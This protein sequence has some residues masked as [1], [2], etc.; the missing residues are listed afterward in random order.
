MSSQVT[1]TQL[2]NALPLTGT[3]AVPI[4]QNGVTVQT[5]TSSISGAGALNYP[6]LTVSGTQGLTQARYLATGSGLSLTDNGIGNSLQ[7][8]LTGA[9]QSL[10]TSSSGIQV[11]NGS[12]VLNGVQIATS[13]SGLSVTNADGTT[14]NP[15][16]ALTGIVANLASTSGS[17]L[18]VANNGSISPTSINGT[19]GQI[20]VTNGSG[21]AVIQQLGL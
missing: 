4:V 8:N 14:G 12:G 2:P 6:F 16:L 1:I 3:E 15:T 17:G 9:A 21:V 13:G 20:N 10:D 5:T 19:S 18:L 11:K 7:I